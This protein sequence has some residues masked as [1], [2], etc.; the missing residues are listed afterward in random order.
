MLVVGEVHD[1]FAQHLAPVGRDLLAGLV[2]PLLQRLEVVHG[3]AARAHRV[4]G[5]A[6]QDRAVP[7]AVGIAAGA[8]QVVAYLLGHGDVA[9][10]A[11]LMTFVSFLGGLQLF[12]MG[13]FGEYLGQ[14]FDEVKRR[15]RYLLAVDSS[16][17]LLPRGPSERADADRE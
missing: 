11:S 9:G 13:I 3:A 17:P 5:G 10:W 16:H 1:L 12:F 2:D 8:G 15:P 4:L 14:V 7:T 6:V